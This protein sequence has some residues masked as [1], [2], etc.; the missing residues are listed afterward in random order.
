M[1]GKSTTEKVYTHK[2]ISQLVDAVNLLP[3]GD[4]INDMYKLRIGGVTVE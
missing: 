3:Y 2:S 1:A 4:D